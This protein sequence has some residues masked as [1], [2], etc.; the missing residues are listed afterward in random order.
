MTMSDAFTNNEVQV[1]FDKLLNYCQANNWAG[2]EPYDAL[3]SGL[4]NRLP[5]LDRRLPRI[6]LT[7]ALKRSPLN[8]RSLLLMP[9]KQNSK[10]IAVFLSAFVELSRAQVMR[11]EPLGAYMV[12]RLIALRSPGER[13][14]CWGYSFPWQ[15]RTVLVPDSAANLVCTVFVASALLDF[16]ELSGDPRSLSMARS[17]AEYILNKLYWTDGNK[18][19]FAYPLPTVRTQIHNANFL[20]A[21]L[22]CRIS[23]HTGE[24]KFVSPAVAAARS[25]AAGQQADGSWFYGEA[26]TQNWIDNFHTGY[27][28]CALRSIGAH[29]GSDEFESSVRRGFQFYRAHFFREDGAV[30]YFHDRDYPVD[31]HCVA[32]SIMTLLAL[33]DLDPD[34]VMLAKSV[35]RWAMDNMWDDRGFFY[36]QFHRFTT[37][38]ISYMRWSQAWMFLALAKLL[39]ACKAEDKIS[40]TLSRTAQAGSAIC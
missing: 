18:Y 28:L 30:R 26:G 10:P 35:F 36:Y 6:V 2:Y 38:R 37:N 39:C 29:T 11:T 40:D 16:Y 13:D 24:E 19:G 7:Q 25:S 21:A 3:N 27:N 12:E 1:A 34:N 23:K 32:Q 4:I 5:F 22:L 15:T 8:I 9:K 33:K 17:A 31:A 14:W 20:A